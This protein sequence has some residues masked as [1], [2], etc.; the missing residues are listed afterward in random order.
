MWSINS[1]FSLLFIVSINQILPSCHIWV[2]G[3][4]NLSSHKA[5]DTH[6][7]P[8]YWVCPYTKERAKIRLIK[9]SHTMNSVLIVLATSQLISNEI[10]PNTLYECTIMRSSWHH[11]FTFRTF[12]IGP[13][14]IQHFHSPSTTMQ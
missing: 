11:L 14:F 12:F 13:E 2:G 4:V 8:I 9:Y 3:G 6:L 1:L 10:D 7:C 5:P